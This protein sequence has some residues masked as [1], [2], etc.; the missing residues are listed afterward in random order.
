LKNLRTGQESELDFYVSAQPN[1]PLLGLQACRRLK[2]LKPIDEN[3]CALRANQQSQNG[4][5]ID[6]QCI[7]EALIYFSGSDAFRAIEALFFDT[8]IMPILYL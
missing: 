8:K 1:Q 7:T 3:I 2:L 4:T 6:G 5:V